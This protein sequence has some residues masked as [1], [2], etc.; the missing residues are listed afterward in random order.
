[1]HRDAIKNL[2]VV[3]YPD[4]QPWQVRNAC[5]GPTLENGP[6]MARAAEEDFYYTYLSQLL[7]PVEGHEFARRDSS[8]VMVSFMER[9]L[10]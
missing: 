7:D 3:A 1:V 5:L 4:V 9:H 8:L 6:G 2:C 10:L